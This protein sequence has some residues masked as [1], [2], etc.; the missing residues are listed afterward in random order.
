MYF[1][2]IEKQKKLFLGSVNDQDVIEGL[3]D[4]LRKLAHDKIIQEELVQRL[5][6]QAARYKGKYKEQKAKITELEHAEKLLASSLND[7]ER[8]FERDRGTG[9]SKVQKLEVKLQR[10]KDKVRALVA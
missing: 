7:R 9:K 8:E 3:K 1:E 10:K 2:Q 6:T 4:E 5:E